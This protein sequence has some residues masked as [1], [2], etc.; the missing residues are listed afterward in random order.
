MRNAGFHLLFNSDRAD[1][2]NAL[3]S[4][5]SKRVVRRFDL[6]KM[7]DLN[8]IMGNIFWILALLI[9]LAGFVWLTKRALS[10]GRQANPEPL[11]EDL[12]PDPAS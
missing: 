1:N 9:S 3:Y 2:S 4:A 7:P 11:P 12:P 8:W 6:A 5:R 10:A